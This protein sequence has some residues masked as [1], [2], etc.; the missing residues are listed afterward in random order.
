M[1]CVIEP[2]N[3]KHMLFI[4]AFA[5]ICLMAFSLTASCAKPELEEDGLGTGN[6]H[7]YKI[8]D[9]PVFSDIDG[10]D[11]PANQGVRNVLLNA[12]QIVNL[13][14]TPIRNLYKPGG[15]IGTGSNV[16]GLVYSSTR[17]EDLYCPNN[18]SFWTF[19]SSLKNPNSFLYTVDITEP[20]YSIHGTARAIY[21]QVCTQF[22]QY[23]LG[24]KYNFQIHQMTVWNGFDTVKPQDI[25]KLRLGDV[26]TSERKGH[27]RLVTGIRR[28]EGKIVEIAISEGVSP[29]AKRTVFPVSEIVNSFNDGYVFYRYRYIGRTK[30]EPSPFVGV[31]DVDYSGLFPDEIM[32]RRG[33]KANWRKDEN[34]VIDVLSRN[35]FTEYKMYKDDQLLLTSK[36]PDSNVINLGVMPY[37]DYKLCLTDGVKDSRCVYWIVADYSITAQAIGG[38]KVK[39]RF[40]SRNATPVWT[41]WR[42]PKESSYNYNDGPLWTT[43]IRDNDARNG[44]VVTELDEYHRNRIGLG[45]WEFKVAF[46]TKYGIISSDSYPV[47]VY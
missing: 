19:L 45:L 44:Y 34:V 1:G 43:V 37:G 24:I 42:I 26:L 21:G 47:T 8:E 46:E 29:T 39:V 16:E 32:P 40:S 2:K 5:L 15:V 38:G 36:I 20:P 25:E 27:T 14:Y 13:S 30:H 18:V 35:S 4:R 7:H 9:P 33:D 6:I 12:E 23:A 3:L 10:W 22:V 11:I 41:T 28:E 31:A 17:A